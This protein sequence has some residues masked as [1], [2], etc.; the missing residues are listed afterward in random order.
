MAMRRCERVPEPRFSYASLTR[1]L[2]LAA[3]CSL[4]VIGACS[5]AEGTD[6]DGSSVSGESGASS[7]EGSTTNGESESSEASETT[8]T[9]STTTDTTDTGS[10]DC[11][12][13]TDPTCAA[14]GGYVDA[15]TVQA[16][17][18]EGPLVVLD[19]RSTGEYAAGHLPGAVNVDP[20]SVRATIDGVSGQVA[21]DTTLSTVFATAGVDPQTPV[22]VY[23]ANIETGSARLVWTLKYAGHGAPV[24][25]L[26]G[27]FASWSDEGRPTN[28]DP[29]PG[30]LSDYPLQK[31]LN[32]RVDGSWVFENLADTSVTLVD[33]RSSAEYQGGHIPGAIHVDWNAN[34]GSAGLF[35]AAADLLELYMNPPDAQILVVYCATGS[36][37]SVAWVVLRALGFDD[38]RLYDGS[39]SEW[40]ANSAWPTEP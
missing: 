27:G 37:A 15:A 1:A 30:P 26:D 6:S 7:L 21:D 19:G 35:L 22:V 16:W 9:D 34:V 14:D 20:A 31:Q 17:I 10:N 4:S 2:P 5:S 40:S 38:V 23:G 33:A 18:D 11:G 39:W 12:P 8:T 13:A 36:R 24:Y 29:G 28:T 3:L 32:L 25:L